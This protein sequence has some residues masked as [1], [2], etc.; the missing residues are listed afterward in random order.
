[1]KKENEGKLSVFGDRVVIKPF[2]VTSKQEEDGS[3]LYLVNGERAKTKDSYRRSP[4]AGV[5][6]YVGD[7]IVGEHK[8]PMLIEAGDIVIF[9]KPQVFD[10]MNGNLFID[11]KT[12]EGLFIL[13]RSNIIYTL[14]Y[15]EKTFEEKEK[16][17]NQ[18]GNLKKETYD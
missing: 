3:Q 15:D 7:G 12:G 9:D 2:G 1:M 16:L 17:Y 13:R 6:M 8:T 10:F 18:I 4:L 14:H 11:P 5:V